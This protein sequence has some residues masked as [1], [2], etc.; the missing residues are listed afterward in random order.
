[1]TSAMARKERGKG[2][3][4]LVISCPKEND[5]AIKRLLAAKGRQFTQMP[6]K[7]AA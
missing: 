5:Q 4:L 7:S 2:R 1:M 6:V 3:I